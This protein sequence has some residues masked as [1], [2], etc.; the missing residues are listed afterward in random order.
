MRTLI[1]VTTE[2]N[3]TP[4]HRLTALLTG[5]LLGAAGVLLIIGANALF[6]IS[7]LSNDRLA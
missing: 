5:V 4:P 7:L 6:W 2:T 1:R 3:P